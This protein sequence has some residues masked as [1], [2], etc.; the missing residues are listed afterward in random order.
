MRET[1]FLAKSI[2][3]PRW[4]EAMGRSFVIGMRINRKADVSMHVS[5]CRAGVLKSLR[6]WSVPQK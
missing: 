5:V 1:E 6:D 3:L 2:G 4:Q